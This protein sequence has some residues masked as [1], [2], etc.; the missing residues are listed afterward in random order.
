MSNGGQILA[1]DVAANLI[2]KANEA[3]SEEYGQKQP[4]NWIP[5]VFQVRPIDQMNNGLCRWS[6][7]RAAT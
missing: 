4:E 6:A 7:N 5:K 3:A 2:Y 1:A